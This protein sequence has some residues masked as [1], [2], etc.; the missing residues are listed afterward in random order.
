MTWRRT[1][2]HSSNSRLR[3]WITFQP[4]SP[5][6]H[7]GRGWQI[8]NFW[9]GTMKWNI[10]A[11]S[12]DWNLIAK[13]SGWH[14]IDSPPPPPTIARSSSDCNFNISEL[15]VLW[16]QPETTHRH[17]IRFFVSELLAYVAAQISVWIDCHQTGGLGHRPLGNHEFSSPSRSH[18]LQCLPNFLS[19]RYR[20]SFLG[21]K[22]AGHEADHSLQSNARVINAW[23]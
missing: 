22:T 4:F 16:L 18:N 23:R 21:V 11:L 3:N 19:N 2:Q 9:L 10:P 7:R 12:G 14:C 5:C 13:S 8:L 6:I 15:R 17:F 20:G 1:W